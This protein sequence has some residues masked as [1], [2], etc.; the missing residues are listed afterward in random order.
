M[1]RYY[2]LPYKMA[3]K[4]SKA[5]ARALNIT[6]VYPDR[7]YK[8][9]SNH[10]LI[11]WGYSTKP[12]IP[13]QGCGQILNSFS[14]I[15]YV[16]NKLAFFKYN[17]TARKV[18]YATSMADAR[19]LFKFHDKVFCRTLINARGGEG[20]VVANSPD[21]LVEAPL[22]TGGITYKVK[23][24]RIHVFR[25]QVF[26]IQQKRKMTSE[27]LEDLGIKHKQGIRNHDNGYVFSINNIEKPSKYT[28]AEA[29][30]VI[31]DYAL[32][33]GAVDILERRE[34]SESYILEVNTAPNLE[35]TTL[36][37]YTQI[38]TEH[39]KTL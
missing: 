1:F 30:Q 9:R 22:Y 33:F 35:G 37:K 24:Y 19:T 12:Q 20:I 5:L 3:S 6:R 23:E 11:N 29:K 14:S 8:G 10:I 18:P 32:D 16:S 2:L 13:T 7:K 26:H 4:S 17:S 27:K 15:P 21:E 25:G 39:L 31:I 38:F 34:T 28:I 36:D